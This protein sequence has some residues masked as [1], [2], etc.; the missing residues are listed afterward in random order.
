MI[1]LSRGSQKKY[2]RVRNWSDC[3][4]HIL[5]SKEPGFI[6][7]FTYHSG[8]SSSVLDYIHI[9]QNRTELFSDFEAQVREDSYHQP[10][11]VHSEGRFDSRLYIPDNEAMC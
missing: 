9:T 7:P 5:D 2:H 10:I 8:I 6:Y 1:P 3:K 4:F 11:S